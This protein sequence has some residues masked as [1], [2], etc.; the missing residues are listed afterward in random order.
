MLLIPINL[1]K[2]TVVSNSIL[3]AAKADVK[4]VSA[5]GQVVKAVAVNENSAVDVSALPAGYYIVTGTVNGKA[6]SQKIIKK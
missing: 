6:V 5:N 2:N 1:V 3:F 4:I